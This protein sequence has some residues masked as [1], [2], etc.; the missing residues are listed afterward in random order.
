LAKV[1]L[2]TVKISRLAQLYRNKNQTS[3]AIPSPDETLLVAIASRTY[4]RVSKIESGAVDKTARFI[5]SESR[6]LVFPVICV[7]PLRSKSGQLPKTV[8]TNE[9]SKISASL[10]NPPIAIHSCCN[11]LKID[12]NCSGV[13]ALVRSSYIVTCASVFSRTEGAGMAVGYCL[14]MGSGEADCGNIAIFSSEYCSNTAAAFGG[15]IK[16][17]KFR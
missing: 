3:H 5:L 9:D 13:S 16:S 1:Q 8:V 14:Y 7:N 17:R 15:S 10:T 6:Q 12:L 4:E 11:L 2:R